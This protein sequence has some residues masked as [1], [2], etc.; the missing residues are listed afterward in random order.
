MLENKNISQIEHF[1]EAVRGVGQHSPATNTAPCWEAELTAHPQTLAPS[2]SHQS[3]SIT[4][5]NKYHI[6]KTPECN[7]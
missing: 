1:Q 5:K 7:S 2:K 6:A 3:I 4:K